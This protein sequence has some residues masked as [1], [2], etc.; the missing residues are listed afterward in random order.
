MLLE[1]FSKLVS[2]RTQVT[3]ICGIFYQ[4]LI[5]SSS[6][7]H[8]GG[9]F[10][11]DTRPPNLVAQ[12]INRDF[13]IFSCGPIIWNTPPHRN[14]PASDQRFK[15]NSLICSRFS[16]FPS[17]EAELFKE[18]LKMLALLSHIILNIRFFQN[19]SFIAIALSPSHHFSC[20]FC[21]SF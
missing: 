15:D 3:K 1:Q 8:C 2:A 4:L 6:V 13:S 7:C 12:L 17:S 5:S 19:F 9:S 14:P 21:V 20:H 11:V 18:L 16:S 10:Y